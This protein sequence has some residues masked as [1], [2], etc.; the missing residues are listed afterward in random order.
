MSNYNGKLVELP[1]KGKALFLQISMEILTIMMDI[2][3]YGENIEM[4]THILSLRAILS[5]LWERRMINI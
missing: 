4:R 3:I 1:K 2:W 5:M